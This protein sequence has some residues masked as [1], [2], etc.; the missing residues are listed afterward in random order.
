MYRKFYLDLVVI[1]SS[2]CFFLN[3]IK[4]NDHEILHANL[5][6]FTHVHL[7]LYA[8]AKSFKFVTPSIPWSLFVMIFY[9]IS[10]LHETF[11]FYVLLSLSTFSLL[12][13]S[14]ISWFVLLG[15]ASPAQTFLL[16]FSMS[17][18]VIY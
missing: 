6:N 4:G 14:C 7:I 15:V 2:S 13:N 1:C 17:L 11:V 9:V 8:H 18:G 10:V 16:S 3:W 12:F 5:V